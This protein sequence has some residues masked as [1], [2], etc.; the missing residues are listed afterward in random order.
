[1]PSNLQNVLEP[2]RGQQ[3]DSRGTP[4]DDGIGRNGRTME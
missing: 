4:L 2:S 1:M 3:A